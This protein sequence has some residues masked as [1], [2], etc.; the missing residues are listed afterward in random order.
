MSKDIPGLAQVM[1]Y[2]TAHELPAGW[3]VE[4]VDADHIRVN[5]TDGGNILIARKEDSPSIIRNFFA[6]FASRPIQ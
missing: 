6:W 4:R 3:T 1:H 5:M 2:M